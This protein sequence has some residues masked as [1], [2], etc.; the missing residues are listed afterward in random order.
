MTL[1]EWP[2]APLVSV[3]FFRSPS[4]TQ[5]DAGGI[6][7]SEGKISEIRP[8]QGHNSDPFY[9]HMLMERRSLESL[10]DVFKSKDRFH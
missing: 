6:H 5:A 3:I 9:S 7:N 4:E 10:A 8:P 1:G 2:D